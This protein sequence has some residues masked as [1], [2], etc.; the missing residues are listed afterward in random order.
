MPN[1]GFDTA[2]LIAFFWKLFTVQRITTAE[3]TA[4][5]TMPIIIS[6]VEILP[7]TLRKMSEI[8]AVIGK[9]DRK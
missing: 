3:Q 4:R 8:G 7:T 1:F 9:Y 5:S 6:G 2:K